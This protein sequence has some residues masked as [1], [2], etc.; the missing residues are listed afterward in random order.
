VTWL[1]SCWVVA[2]AIQN[3]DN[4][5]KAANATAKTAWGTLASLLLGLAAAA[6]GGHVG[7]RT[8]THDRDRDRTRT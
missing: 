2:S 5:N 3:P 1:P 4:Q 8:Q 6:F 7:S